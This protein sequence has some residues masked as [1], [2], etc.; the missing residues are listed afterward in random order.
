LSDQSKRRRLA[1]INEDEVN[2][3]LRLRR[4]KIVKE[5]DTNELDE[6]ITSAVKG[7]SDYLSAKK[8]AVDI[9]VV[10]KEAAKEVV[11]EAI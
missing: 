3:T 10:A 2:E 8:V 9:E 6:V 1:S 7:F 11:K 4:R 5:G